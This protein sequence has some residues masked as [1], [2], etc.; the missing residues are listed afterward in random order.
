M[1]Q[2]CPA[3]PEADAE[4]GAHCVHS[5][6]PA[7]LKRP[8]GHAG[9]AAVRL[10]AEEAVPAPHG[11]H[12]LTPAADP[13]DPAGHGRHADALDAPR[14]GLNV[15]STHAVVQDAEFSTVE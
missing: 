2:L 1:G 13:N 12:V 3:T 7:T 5:V 8:D 10:V 11:L 14:E 9:H 4:P 6:A 15:P